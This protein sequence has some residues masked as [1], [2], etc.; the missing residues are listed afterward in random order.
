MEHRTESHRLSTGSRAMRRF[1]PP[2][3]IEEL[4]AGFKIVDGNGQTL[5]YV[6]GHADPRDAQIA[7]SLT[8][9][10]RIA[11]NIAKLPALLPFSPSSRA[12][13]LNVRRCVTSVWETQADS[14]FSI[15]LGCF[16][17]RSSSKGRTTPVEN[18]RLV[19][20][21]LKF[22]QVARM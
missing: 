14:S 22:G 5:A 12:R 6:Y 1:P 7:N 8:E 20:V 2:W 16:G 4:E 17:R 11:N 3:T 10:R 15:L 18:R 13:L 9:A 19:S 21:P